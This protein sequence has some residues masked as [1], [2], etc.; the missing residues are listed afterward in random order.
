MESF[1]AMLSQY[2]GRPVVDQTELKGKYHVSLQLSMD[3]LMAVARN[4]GMNPGMVPNN[5]AMPADAA[6]EPSSGGPLFASV[7]QL[8]LRLESRKLPYDM[9]VIEHVEKAPTEN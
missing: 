9:V 8:G 6:S 2:L 3:T 1:A 7:Q 5:S 4:M